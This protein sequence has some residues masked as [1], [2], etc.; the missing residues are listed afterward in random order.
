MPSGTLLRENRGHR[1]LFYISTGRGLRNQHGFSVDAKN[2]LTWGFHGPVPSLTRFCMKN[3]LNP[4]KPQSQAIVVEIP[5]F[6]RTKI[7]SATITPYL[8]SGANLRLF[9]LYSKFCKIFKN[10][11]SS[12]EFRRVRKNSE[13]SGRIQKSPQNIHRVFNMFRRVRR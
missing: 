12:E 5:R 1:T 7:C 9:W 6:D 3:R 4:C 8:N 11:E 10:P 13:E 2:S